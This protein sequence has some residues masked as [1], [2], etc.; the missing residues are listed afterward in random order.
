MNKSELVKDISSRINFKSWTLISYLESLNLADLELI[1]NK[2]IRSS[3]NLDIVCLILSSVSV[4]TEDY[5]IIDSNEHLC[6]GSCGFSRD[7]DKSCLGIF[8]D[9]IL[10][11]RYPD[12]EE[13][14]RG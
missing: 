4:I 1:Y 8:E 12:N 3:Y 5:Y 9:Y 11:R 13:S 6:K 10:S 7:G 2:I 14:N